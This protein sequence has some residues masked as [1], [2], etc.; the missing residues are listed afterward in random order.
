[1]EEGHEIAHQVKAAI[2]QND[3]RVVDVLVHIE[4]AQTV[5]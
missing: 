4:P 1:V 5:T 2:Q 3:S